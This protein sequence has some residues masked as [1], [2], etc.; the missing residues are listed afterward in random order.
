MKHGWKAVV[1]LYLCFIRLQSVANSASCFSLA[2]L[3]NRLRPGIHLSGNPLF[4]FRP[5][6]RR[7][8][9]AVGTQMGRVLDVHVNDLVGRLLRV[10][11]QEDA[12]ATA[13]EPG[14]SNS[15][16]T[17]ARASNQPN[18]LAARA[19][20]SASRSVVVEKIALATSSARMLFWRI[21]KAKSSRVA[22]RIA[23]P[24]LALAVVAPRIP[25]HGMMMVSSER[26]FFAAPVVYP[27]V[28]ENATAKICR[29]DGTF[30]S[31]HETRVLVPLSLR[32][33]DGVRGALGT[34]RLS[35]FRICSSVPSP[36][37]SPGGRG[38]P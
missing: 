36:Q 29:C 5:V 16:R 17:T 14:T 4:Q 9:R 23:S 6:H 7:Q 32:E 31:Y 28:E 24:V 12:D 30:T 37:P 20:N 34:A 21:I 3:P 8:L 38:G 26:V 18:C 1:F 11:V 10:P 19:G 15:S 22:L 35:E 25:R 2:S 13:D 33:R 27:L